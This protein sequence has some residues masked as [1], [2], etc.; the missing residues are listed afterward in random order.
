MSIFFIRKK[1]D[2]CFRKWFK[3]WWQN[4]CRS[5][6]TRLSGISLARRLP[7]T[8]PEEAHVMFPSGTRVISSRKIFSVEGREEEGLTA[9]T[10]GGTQDLPEEMATPSPEQAFGGCAREHV[11]VTSQ[12][13]FQHSGVHVYL[14][15][16]R[17][18]PWPLLGDRERRVKTFAAL[19]FSSFWNVTNNTHRPV[20]LVLLLREVPRS[21]REV[22]RERRSE[23]GSW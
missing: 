10:T 3:V 13:A 4:S 17:L 8:L 16:Q 11:S 15:F 5:C 9:F 22:T 20:P 7:R 6:W 19:F 1:K 23:W 12:R 2:T 14:L 21:F 18:Q